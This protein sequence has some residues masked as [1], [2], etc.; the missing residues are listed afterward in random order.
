MRQ[1]RAQF[2]TCSLFL[3]TQKTYGVC[4]KTAEAKDFY[5]MLS[6]GAPKGFFNLDQLTK[7][8][9]VVAKLQYQKSF[10][11]EVQ[12]AI[13]PKKS[14]LDRFI[15]ILQT[16]ISFAFG[17]TRELIQWMDLSGTGTIKP[18]E[19]L[20]AVRFFV[21]SATFSESMLIFKQL[22]ANQDGFLDEKELAKIL[23]DSKLDDGDRPNKALSYR[24]RDDVHSGVA[25]ADNLDELLK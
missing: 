4:L 11:T 12:A 10:E 7:V 15:R 24:Y 9:Q 18:E 13:E 6:L 22:D 5:D 19:F 8:L 25:A 17:S 21:K 2:I 20:L 14:Y 16:K 3:K 23:P 1:A